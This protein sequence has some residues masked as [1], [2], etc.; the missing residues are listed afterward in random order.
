MN[1]AHPDD[2]EEISN[3]AGEESGHAEQIS[4]NDAN[5]IPGRMTHATSDPNIIN[6]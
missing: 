1:I 4:E 3:E 2:E 5:Q 6:K